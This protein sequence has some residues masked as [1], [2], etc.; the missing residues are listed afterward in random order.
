MIRVTPVESFFPS[1]DRETDTLL[2]WS[3]S[4]EQR[5]LG[6]PQFLARSAP[7]YRADSVVVIDYDD[8]GDPAVRSRVP[9]FAPAVRRL[10]A[11]FAADRR[12]HQET[13][14]PYGVLDGVDYFHTLFNALPE[15]SSV[16]V[17]VSTLSKLHVLLLIEQRVGGSQMKLQLA[18]E[19]G[20]G[21]SHLGTC[22]QLH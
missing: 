11:T 2:V 7:T 14:D 13:L 17:D 1:P 9:R 21:P 22:S 20:L 12:L 15:Q 19:I 6:F 3:T 16:V 4:F 10:G 5:C 18:D 8:R